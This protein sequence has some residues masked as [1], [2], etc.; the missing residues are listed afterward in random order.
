MS[1]DD[2][3]IPG[4]RHQ[5]SGAKRNRSSI[6]RRKEWSPDYEGETPHPQDADP[7]AYPL[8]ARGIRTDLP[9]VLLSDL[10]SVPLTGLRSLPVSET[11]RFNREQKRRENS[12]RVS[13]DPQ[14]SLRWASEGS[15]MGRDY[16]GDKVR[17]R[18]EESKLAK[19]SWV[20][21]RSSSFGGTVNP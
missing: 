4:D 1:N 17:R 13:S 15:P 12:A 21:K 19:R 11:S 5:G 18:S 20:K 14:T 6:A 3:P 10:L 9:N 2:H 16:L 8:A 7:S